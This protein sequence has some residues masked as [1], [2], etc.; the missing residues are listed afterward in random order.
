AFLPE[1]DDLRVELVDLVAQASEL[2]G[3]GLV[4]AGLVGGG[5][6]HQGFSLY[7]SDRMSGSEPW[8]RENPE[9][10]AR[11]CRSVVSATTY[12]SDDPCRSKSKI[13]RSESRGQVCHTPAGV[14]DGRVGLVS[15]SG[16][17]AGLRRGPSARGIGYL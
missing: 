17:R 1:A 9:L 11:G 2:V 15:D 10:I 12:G 3:A 7:V 16:S 13:A 4:G 14:T 6:G 5:G 8:N